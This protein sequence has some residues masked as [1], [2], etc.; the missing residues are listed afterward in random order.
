MGL[1]RRQ[2]RLLCWTSDSLLEYLAVPLSLSCT[3]ITACFLS[4][5]GSIPL[6]HEER[7]GG[8][9]GGESGLYLVL[10]TS[11]SCWRQ[12][13]W[14]RRAENCEAVQLSLRPAHW[15][16]VLS[17]PLHK[18]LE[19]HWHLA[20]WP[21]THTHNTHTQTHTHTHTLKSCIIKQSSLLCPTQ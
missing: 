13:E 18:P 11:I 16:C 3:S 2:T 1:D 15:V 12:S 20:S 14:Q 7:E 21:A 19:T 4:E 8:S 10:T 17:A 5:Y 9:E 6:S